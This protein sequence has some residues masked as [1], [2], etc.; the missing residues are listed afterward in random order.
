[1]TKST[2]TDIFGAAIYDILARIKDAVSMCSGTCWLQIL[3]YHP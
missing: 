1:M 2:G 3:S